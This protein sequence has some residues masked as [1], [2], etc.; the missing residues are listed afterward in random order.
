MIYFSIIGM[1]KPNKSIFLWQLKLTVLN[2]GTCCIGTIELEQT[3]T[4]HAGLN[5]DNM[6]LQWPS[7]KIAN[8]LAP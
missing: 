8:L 1:K 4:K 6:T 7:Q 2:K 5:F 3:Y